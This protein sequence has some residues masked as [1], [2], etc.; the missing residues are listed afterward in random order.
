MDVELPNGQVLH[1]R[2]RGSGTPIA[3]LLHGWVV[4]SEVW[5]P[6]LQR[7]PEAG[8]GRLIAADLRGTGWS[9]KPATGYGPTDHAGDVAM[10]L[11]A[12]E[13]T[14]VMLV[15]HSMGGQIAQLVALER[16]EALSR[17]VLLCP[18]PASGVPFPENEVEFLHSL[19]G[20]YAGV[21]QVISMLMKSATDSDAFERVVLA[22][23]ATSHGAFH[24]AF[25]AWRSASF[26]ASR[27]RTPTAVFAAEL[28]EALPPRLVE[29]TA[30]AMSGASF[31]VLEGCGHYPTLECPERLVELLQNQLQTAT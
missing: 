13:L 2:R 17:L 30:K 24:E 23:A 28:D 14:E 5:Q 31:S 6:V 15:G 4:S 19:G 10:L 22:A 18:V 21:R 29:E 3:L 25:D 26:D 16:P 11:D 27:I 7:W 8:A 20:H 1:I 12:L 9:S